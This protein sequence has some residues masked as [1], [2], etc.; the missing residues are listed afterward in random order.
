MSWHANVS[1]ALVA[2][3]GE[4]PMPAAYDR[5]FVPAPADVLVRTLMAWPAQWL[6]PM[7]DVHH[8][9]L[10]AER[11]G[12][13]HLPVFGF[14]ELVGIVC[15]CDL[16]LAPSNEC[17]HE[18][19]HIAPILISADAPASEAADCMD[20]HDVG[21][22]VVPHRGWFGILTHGDLCRAGVVAER[23]S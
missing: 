23:G 17:V 7:L 8:A 22:L 6:S 1:R 15:V 10:L 14:G 12:V 3:H 9:L 19:M 2:L 4:A 13:H 21:C 16:R 5:D 11:L 20:S 18:H